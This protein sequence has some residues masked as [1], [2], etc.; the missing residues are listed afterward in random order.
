VENDL[1][2]GAESSDAL[3]GAAADVTQIAAVATPLEEPMPTPRDAAQVVV[4][5]GQTVIRVPVAPG[6]VVEL[7][8]PADAHFQAR[9]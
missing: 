3:F 7:P 4:P 8:F 6:E 5:Q 2:F 1:I 9:L